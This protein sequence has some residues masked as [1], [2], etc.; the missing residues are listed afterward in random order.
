MDAAALRHGIDQTVA[1][2]QLEGWLPTADDLAALV[3]LARGELRYGEYLATCRAR[4]PAAERDESV[5]RGRRR[6]FRRRTPYLLPGTTLLRNNFG[7]E[8]PAVLQDLE[9]VA[10]AG[11]IVLWHCRLAFGGAAQR[12][13]D[14]RMLHQHVFA[15]VYPWAGSYRVTELRRGE[16][17]FSW[18]SSVLPAM[19]RIEAAARRLAVTGVDLD[20]AALGY[21]FARLYADYNQVHPFREGNGRTGTLL[22]HTVAALRCAGGGSTSR[23]S[24]A[25]S[26]TRRRGTACRSVVTDTP[27]TGRSYRCSSTR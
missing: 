10:S 7:A 2:E 20:N 12:D 17:A 8:S 18:Q 26:G 5:Q 25:T 14:V 19:A 6:I 27:T 11:R 13:V 22:L 1:A 24:P 15:D 4:R 21:A 23:P 9:F 16:A 3:D